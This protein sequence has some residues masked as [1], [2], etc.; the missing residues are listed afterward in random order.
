MLSKK[1]S[2]FASKVTIIIHIALYCLL[3]YVLRNHIPFLKNL[4]Y[5]YLTAILFVVD[6]LI[7]VIL[8]KIH[9]LEHDYVQQEHLD[10]SVNMK[11]WKY[12]K[13]WIAVTIGITVL[14]YAV[15]SPLGFGKSEKTTWQ[16]YQESQAAEDAG[17]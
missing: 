15:F 2:A 6:V 1:A 12:R 16:M 7:M 13:I 3:N 8:T 4:H 14:F 10:Y 17:E 11:P 5:L 9:P